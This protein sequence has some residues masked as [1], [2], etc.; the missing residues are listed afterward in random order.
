MHGDPYPCAQEYVTP[1]ELPS[2][3]MWGIFIKWTERK[4]HLATQ[5]KDIFC[6]VCALLGIP[7]FLPNFC[8]TM[9]ALNIFHVFFY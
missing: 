3:G 7:V 1:S 8:G 5:P 2:K 4:A 9:A 6:F